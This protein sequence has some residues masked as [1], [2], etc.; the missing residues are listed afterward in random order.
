M[1]CDSYYTV[2]SSNDH[3]YY[4]KQ[5][6]QQHF[7]PQY[8]QTIFAALCSY[9][10]LGTSVRAQKAVLLPHY[11]CSS[12]KNKLFQNLHQH[13]TLAS[14][15]RLLSR[16]TG[17]V[18]R[19]NLKKDILQGGGAMLFTTTA[20]CFSSCFLFSLLLNSLL[21][22]HCQYYQYSIICYI[23][24][25]NHSKTE[26]GT[27]VFL[28]IVFNCEFQLFTLPAL[29]RV[30]PAKEHKYPMSCLY[31][32]TKATFPLVPCSPSFF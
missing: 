5:Y 19:K 7:C 20:F 3:I 17:A 29:K 12:Y 21:S 18:Q 6:L 26:I 24:K 13:K 32:H 9:H 31:M 30:F 16:T 25:K 14:K 1:A 15:Y 27:L 4:R 10:W 2:I 28:K 11:C 22:L 23:K 8:C